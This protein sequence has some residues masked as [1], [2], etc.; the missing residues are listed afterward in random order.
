MRLW[1]EHLNANLAAGEVVETD[2]LWAKVFDE[3]SRRGGI[4]TD[5][6]AVATRTFEALRRC[7]DDLEARFALRLPELSMGMSGD[8]EQAIAAGATCVRVGSA[9]FGERPS[10]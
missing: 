2:L 9:L 3:L 8:L 10:A 7:R 4:A 1:N 6:P 5:D